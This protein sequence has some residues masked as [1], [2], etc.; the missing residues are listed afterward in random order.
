[1]PKLVNYL[2]T[3][4][5][6]LILQASQGHGGELGIW[7]NKVKQAEVLLEAG[8][9]NIEIDAP[10]GYSMPMIIGRK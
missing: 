1:M 3:L 2:G 8:F 5:D 9:T 4:T 7:A 6:H 10:S